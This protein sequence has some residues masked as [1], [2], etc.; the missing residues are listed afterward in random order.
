MCYHS[1]ILVITSYLQKW[2][3]KIV[4]KDVIEVYIMALME[5]LEILQQK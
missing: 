1:F 4:A 3:T 5:E 2:R